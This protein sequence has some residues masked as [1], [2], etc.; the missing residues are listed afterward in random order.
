MSGRPEANG[1]EA[2]LAVLEATLPRIDAS[3]QKISSSL[4]SLA[5]LEAAH[6][7]TN[8]GLGRAFK[9]IKDLREEQQKIKDEMPMLKLAK[10]IVLWF[11]AMC[12]VVVVSYVLYRVDLLVAGGGLAKIP[13]PP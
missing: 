4:E 5:R 13:A 3:L 8:E 7:S 2:R 9:E 6:Q 1:M 10:S 11:G 12:M